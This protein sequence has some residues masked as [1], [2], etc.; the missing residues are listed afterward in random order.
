MSARL[1]AAWRR[2]RGDR[3]GLAS[4]FTVGQTEQALMTQFGRPVR[5]IYDPGLHTKSRS[6]RP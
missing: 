5:V 1:I 4:L 3:A 2:C 6:Y